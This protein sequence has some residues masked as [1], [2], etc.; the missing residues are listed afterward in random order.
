MQE[1]FQNEFL[2]VV[3]LSTGQLSTLRPSERR[4]DIRQTLRKLRLFGVDE[5]I[6]EEATRLDKGIDSFPLQGL[7][8][9]RGH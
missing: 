2:Q 7:L 4:A 8:E 3:A 1:L 6:R 5:R 9:P